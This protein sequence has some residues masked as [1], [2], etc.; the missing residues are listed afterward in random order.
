MRQKGLLRGDFQARLRIVNA[1][2]ADISYPLI[3]ALLLTL[4]GFSLRGDVF[5]LKR[6]VL[7]LVPL[8]NF[9]MAA[10]AHSEDVLQELRQKAEQGDTDAIKAIEEAENEYLTELTSMVSD[11]QAILNDQKYS[12]F[13]RTQIVQGN[14]RT[15]FDYAYMCLNTLDAVCMAV[16]YDKFKGRLKAVTGNE[17]VETLTHRAE[18]GDT[19]AQFYLGLIYSNG[20]GVPKNIEESVNWYRKAAEQGYA[21]AQFNLGVI[22]YIGDGVPKNVTEAMVWWRRAAEQGYAGAIEWY[23]KTAEQ[24]D[25]IAQLNLGVMYSNGKGVPKDST[26]AVWWYRKAA[27][28]GN[29]EAKVGLEWVS[30]N[31]DLDSLDTLTQRAELGD[32]TAQFNLGLIYA[33]GKGVAKNVDTSVRWYRMAAEQGDADAQFNLGV[34]YYNGEG[35]PKNDS[36]AIHWWRMAGQL[37]HAEAIKWY[38]KIAEQAAEKG[39]A[40]AQN[41]LGWMYAEGK[42]VPK[43]EAAAIQWFR[44]A[45]DQGFSEAQFSLGEICFLGFGVEKDYK[46]AREWYKLA[47]SQGHSKATLYATCSTESQRACYGWAIRNEKNPVDECRDRNMLSP[48]ERRLHEEAEEQGFG[49]YGLEG[50]GLDACSFAGAD[51]YLDLASLKKAVDSVIARRREVEIEERRRRESGAGQSVRRQAES[52]PPHTPPRH[53]PP[54]SPGAIDVRTGQFFPSVGGGVIDPRDGTF[55]QK[56]GGGYVNTRTGEF[57]PGQ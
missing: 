52:P 19:T 23:R 46:T 37:G 53:T 16:V 43:N 21:D 7:V 56:T 9:C 45:A 11:R 28:Q 42:V 12:A 8:M 22:F 35:C 24:G 1:S 26:E 15:Y 44:K 27:E 51:G 4:H 2:V 33:K 6:M 18:L 31:N 50:F 20:K 10:V 36:E 34:I 3:R 13:L 57:E 41:E 49:F 14:K 30:A 47:A 29:A 48:N 54:A 17:G 40:F 55:H 38:K 39:D 5:M 32:T 25:A